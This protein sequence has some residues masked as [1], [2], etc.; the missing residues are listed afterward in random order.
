[1]SCSMSGILGRHRVWPKKQQT[2]SRVKTLWGFGGFKSH[3]CIYVRILSIYHPKLMVH[4]SW[5]EMKQHELSWVTVLWIRN[6]ALMQFFGLT[7]TTSEN[8]SSFPSWDWINKSH[9]SVRIIHNFNTLQGVTTFFLILRIINSERPQLLV[10][11]SRLNVAHWGLQPLQPVPFR[12]SV[13]L[14]YWTVGAGF[15]RFRLS[16]RLTWKLKKEAGWGF[17]AVG[18]GPERSY[19]KESWYCWW[20]RNPQQPVEDG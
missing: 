15:V 11:E 5:V 14:W 6:L 3:E 17:P 20:F 16:M 7:K 9:S 4:S 12:S 10:R 1:M 18:N 19:K 2:F 8:I 13:L